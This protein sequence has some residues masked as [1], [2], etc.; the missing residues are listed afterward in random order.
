[1]QETKINREYFSGSQTSLFIG[2]IWVDDITDLSYSL[3]HSRRPIYGYGSQ[4]F[5]FMPK[6]NILIEGSFSINF[7]E[8]NYLWLILSRYEK[9]DATKNIYNEKYKKDKGVEAFN[10]R[11]YSGDRRK[12]FNDFFKTLDP[13]SV[14]EKL[15][16]QSKEFNGIPE[17]NDIENFNHRS[18]NIL[19]GYGDTLNK[20]AIGETIKSV[21]IMGKS[22]I[23]DINGQP[24]KER[25][26]FIAR[27]LV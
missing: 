9:F 8:P 5:D 6:G 12:R 10:A 13:K 20:D 23:I 19:I 24:I 16:E 22:K 2:D 7:R 15:V 14:Q 11:T 17:T 18:F 25:Y 27:K 4:Y 3:T 21:H 26:N 1:M